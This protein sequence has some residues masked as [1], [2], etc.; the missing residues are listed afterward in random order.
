MSIDNQD[1]HVN[2]AFAL[3]NKNVLEYFKSLYPALAPLTCTDNILCLGDESFPLGYFRLSQLNSM[4][5]ELSPKSFFELV[6]ILADIENDLAFEDAYIYSISEIVYKSNLNDKDRE[7]LKIFVNKYLSLKNYEDYLSGSSTITLSKY[8]QVVHNVLYLSDPNNLTEAQKYI[9]EQV[10]AYNESLGGKSNGLSRVLKNPDIPN[11]VPD[12][13]QGFS[14]A[15]F[16]SILLILYAI[17]NAA[18][19]LAIHLIK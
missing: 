10:L 3:Q 8:R 4:I 14:K 1:S 19:M 17:I 6:N 18:I 12:D 13:N 5:C 16:A 2:A 11:M 15:G 7:S 9:T